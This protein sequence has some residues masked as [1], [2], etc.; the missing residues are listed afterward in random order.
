MAQ[1]T[2]SMVVGAALALLIT[3]ATSSSSVINAS[4]SASGGSSAEATSHVIQK[5][6][7]SKIDIVTEVDG[8]R[9]EEHYESH[10]QPLTVSVVSTS[11]AGAATTSGIAVS[12]TEV[13]QRVLSLV[14]SILAFFR[15][16]V[17]DL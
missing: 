14:R 12:R 7:T 10:G 13:V 1:E 4:A 2:R 6:G 16:S 11:S 17:S 15:L 8:I 9:R 3:V 5:G